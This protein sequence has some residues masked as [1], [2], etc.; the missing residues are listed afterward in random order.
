MYL[1]SCPTRIQFGQG[2]VA[3]AAGE[4]SAMG[5]RKPL[6]VTGPGATSASPALLELES[7]LESRGLAFAHFSGALS[8][9]SVEA[10][11]DGAR[12]F[13]EEDC[14]SLIGFGGGSPLDCA[15]GIGAE[16]AEG[17]PI[18]DFIGTGRI[19]AAELPPLIAVP[20]TAGTGSE[21]T[22]AAVF[23]FEREGRRMK[24]GIASPRLFPELAIVDPSLHASMPPAITAWTGMDA[25]TH[26][27]EAYVSKGANPFSD[28][29]CLESVRLIGRHLARAYENGSDMEARSGMALAATL[30]GIGLSQAGLGMVHGYAHALGAICGLS[31]GLAN[32]IMLPKVMEACVPDVARRLADI[33]EALGSGTAPTGIAA[34]TRGATV[35]DGVLAR[36]PETR[37]KAAVEA[38]AALG[39]RLGIPSG[40]KTAGLPESALDSVLADAKTYKRRPQS[41][42][43]FTDEE[44]GA[45]LRRAWE[46]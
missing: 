39:A 11:A 38:I 40:L 32:A 45:I 23:T 14:D 28:I 3:L 9:P 27:V 6:I 36:K 19:V 37:A 43:A 2:S 44:L 17:R 22:G 46:A 15:K 42:R 25:L 1:F 20:T 10:V 21:A 41:P 5:A 16:I 18:S 7:S 26:A 29:F 12:L 35:V 30:A 31:H 34:P 13:R 8:D 24:Q 33:G 4:L